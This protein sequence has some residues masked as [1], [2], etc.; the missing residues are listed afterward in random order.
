MSIAFYKIFVRFDEVLCME[1]REDS[2]ELAE[3]SSIRP[4]P[5]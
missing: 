5:L 1:K 2:V 4:R 3:P